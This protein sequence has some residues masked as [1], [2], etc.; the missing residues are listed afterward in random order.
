MTAAEIVFETT[1]SPLRL[2]LLRD[3]DGR[4]RLCF[5]GMA[6]VPE[7][8]ENLGRFELVQLSGDHEGQ[9][10]YASKG[11]QTTLSIPGLALKYIAH[12]EESD[13][14]G[15][16][17][18][19]DLAG[20]GL[21]ATVHWRL[22]REL[23]VVRAWIEVTN[24]G[25]GPRGLESVA[26]FF[27]AGLERSLGEPLSPDSEVFGCD[28]GWFDELRWQR[29]TLGE[30]GLSGKRCQTTNCFQP[31]NTGNWSTKNQLP[32]GVV[33]GARRS[34]FWQIEH[35]G[36]WL[37]DLGSSGGGLYLGLYGP[38]EQEHHWHRVLRPGETF[39]SVPVCFGVCE[40][41][42]SEAMA[43]LTRYRRRIRRPHTDYRRLPIIFNDYM[44][45]LFADPTSEKERPYIRAAAEAGAEIY[46]VDAGWYAPLGE[47][48]WGT[49]GEWQPSPD[50]FEGGVPGLMEEIRRAGMRPGLW[51][52]LESMGMNCPLAREW[53]A[54]CFF[55]R[56]GKAVVTSGRYQ[57]DFRHPVVRAHADEVVDRLVRDYGVAY[58]KMDYNIDAGIGTEVDADSFGDGLLRHNRAYLDWL[59]AVFDRHPDLVVENCSSGGLRMDYA[60]LSR[61]SLQS[62]SDQEDVLEMARIAAAGPSGATP[63][64]QA[65][66]VYPVRADDRERVIMNCVNGLGLRIHLSGELAYLDPEN[67]A[68]VAEAV[69]FA[70]SLRPALGE[71]VPSWPFGPPT[72]SSPIPA[73]VLRSPEWSLVLVWNLSDREQLVDFPEE[74]GTGADMPSAKAFPAAEAGAWRHIDGILRCC[75]PAGSARALKWAST[76]SASR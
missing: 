8:P 45:C 34:V 69:A 36:S 54:E 31:R 71:S 4:P 64:Q 49:I 58:I 19:I 52:E 44:N 47:S 3:A 73:V 41:G 26:S 40:G 32:C 53:P 7:P 30:L 28:M 20:S 59:D 70:K 74:V 12:R 66:W 37:A 65:M 43:E 16:K 50:R 22:F 39:S 17:V 14:E 42:F 57:L 29:R 46:V 75:L 13:A 61:H 55:R 63:E 6:P 10:G 21:E 51:L 24:A 27:I 56:H 33:S 60:Q 68:L 15:S 9:R 11:S 35:N 18:E 76:G 23:P 5:A 67:R 62:I 72:A 48:W 1:S 38:R 25:D 2:Q